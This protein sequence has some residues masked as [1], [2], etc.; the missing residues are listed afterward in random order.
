MD[1][2]MP[3]PKTAAEYRAVV[4]DLLRQMAQTHERMSHNQ[5]EIDRLKAES[6]WIRADTDRILA[7][8]DTRLAA[9][10]SLL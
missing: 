7:Q 2:S 5:V 8:I 10:N 4:D 1:E 9:I 3:S 6:A